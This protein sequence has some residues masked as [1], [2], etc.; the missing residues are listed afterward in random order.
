MRGETEDRGP[1]MGRLLELARHEEVLEHAELA[2]ERDGALGGGMET[3]GEHVHA[4]VAL[5]EDGEGGA[6][7]G[8][9][10]EEQAGE[11]LGPTRLVAEE[12]AG[13]DAPEDVEH[14]YQENRYGDDGEQAASP[15]AEG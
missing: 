2:E 13:G 8:E 1:E 14:Q 10:D 11:L 9:P 4:E 5:V 7:H 15:E 12:V 3:R 6:E